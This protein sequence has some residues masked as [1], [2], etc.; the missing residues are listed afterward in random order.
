[1]DQ[2][3]F[4]RQMLAK[5]STRAFLT[6]VA[7]MTA[8]MPHPHG[9]AVRITVTTL[10]GGETLGHVDVDVTNLWDLGNLAS[11]RATAPTPTPNPMPA[12]RPRLRLVGGA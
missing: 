2:E 11:R 4:A 1:M 7:R 6:G 9:T 12:D 5:S 3:A 8:A 10:D